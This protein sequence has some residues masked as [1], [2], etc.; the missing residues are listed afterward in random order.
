LR[1]G[2]LCH[3]Q[4]TCAM[5]GTK[6]SRYV[7]VFCKRHTPCATGYNQSVTGCG[8]Q[9]RQCSCYST[10]THVNSMIVIFK[11]NLISLRNIYIKSG[12]RWAPHTFYCICFSTKSNSIWGWGSCCL[13][14]FSLSNDYMF[15]LRTTTCDAL[16]VPSVCAGLITPKHK[17]CIL[18]LGNISWRQPTGGVTFAKHS[19]I[20]E[21]ICMTK[22]C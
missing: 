21:L 3:L 8:S 17:C 4:T 11:L 14:K 13:H 5:H 2:P 6:E 7:A 10:K 22:Y 19:N 16:I 9:R 12:L 15:S 1:N 20:S 18:G